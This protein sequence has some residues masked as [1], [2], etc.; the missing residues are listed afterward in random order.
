MTDLDADMSDDTAPHTHPLGAITVAGEDAATFLRAQLTNDVLRLGP[1]RHFMAGWC[2]AKGRAQMIAQVSEHG[3]G[4]LLIVPRELIEGL[5]KRLR[6]FVLRARVEIADASDSF[7]ISGL[8]GPDLPTANRREQRE[9]QTLLGLPT[10]A[11]GMARALCV[12]P[13]D[14]PVRE[15]ALATGDNAWER[16]EIASGLPKIVGATQGLFVPQMLNLHWLMGIDFDKGCYPGQEVIARLHYRGKLTRRL[17]RMHWY[18]QMPAPGDDVVDS[19]GARQG[20]VV[21]TA[22]DDEGN[23]ALLAAL[24]IAAAEGRLATADA[25]LTLADLPYATPT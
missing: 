10:G 18:G 24:K 4:Y 11:N 1:D 20:T 17:F 9:G 13:T 2:D 3:D 6:M 16:H 23:G 15:D 22:T 7:H 25:D 14:S 5:L 19:D 8:V 21:R 12:T